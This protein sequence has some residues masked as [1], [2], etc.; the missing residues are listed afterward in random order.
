MNSVTNSLLG[1]KFSYI[2]RASDMLCLFIGD[3]YIFSSRGKDIA[4]TE[5]AIHFQTQWRFIGDKSI[6]LGSRDIY[7]PYSHAVAENWEYDII[8]RSDEESSV[9]DV[10]ARDVNRAMRDA[11]V[12]DVAVSD[13]GDV[14]IG[15]SNGVTFQSFIPASNKGEE[16]RFI[17]YKSNRHVVFYEVE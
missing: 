8:G 4:V 3:S 6:I 12:T 11:A 1:K 14:S 16:W 13:Y 9:F 7:E 15:F 5:F 2:S 17:D 10:K